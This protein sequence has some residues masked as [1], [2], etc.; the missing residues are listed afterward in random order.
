MRM[1]LAVLALLLWGAS[2]AWASCEVQV[3]PRTY[4]NGEFIGGDLCDENGNKRVTTSGTSSTTG[5]TANAAAP[6]LVEASQY[7]F[8]L[9]LAGNLRTTLGT[10]LSGE[11]QTNNLLMTSGGA[12][13]G[14]VG[15]VATAVTTNT[16]STAV[17]LPV[18]SKTIYGSVDGTGAV[19]QT[20]AIYGGLTSGVT[21]TTGELLCTLTLS[22]TT[23]A[24]ATCPVITANFLFYI[25][26]STATTGT[27]ATG[28]TTA[29]Y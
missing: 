19:T 14:T 25:M 26:V 28:V 5:G 9:D 24:H 7:G 12:V 15:N 6:T 1:L 2:S 4:A 8:S 21:A 20:Q 11:D 18:G 3:T 16:T 27:G 13:R 29:M 17:A 10:L 22:G 23:H